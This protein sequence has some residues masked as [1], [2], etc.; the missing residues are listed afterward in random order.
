RFTGERLTID[1]FS[2]EGARGAAQGGTLE[3]TGSAEWRPLTDNTR[4][5]PVISL[6]ATADRL[7]VSS[8][9]DRRL[10]LSG[11]M[12][13]QLDGPA[14]KVRGQLKADSAQITLPDDLAP[15][16]GSDVVVRGSGTPIEDPNAQRVQP[17]VQVE[18]D[19]G[20]AFEV[21]GRGL[22][23]RLAGQLS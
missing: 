16:L 19:L 5:Q 20:P 17:D 6:Q 18:L 23:T 1:R 15:S 10:T 8:R 21:S 13:V 3:A 14:L 4:R 7:R 11:N 9:V 12:S 22:Q 2:L